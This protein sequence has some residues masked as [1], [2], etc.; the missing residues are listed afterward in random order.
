MKFKIVPRSVQDAEAD[1]VIDLADMGMARK[2]IAKEVYGS[3][4]KGEPSHS[5]LMRIQHILSYWGVGVTAYRNG[6]NKHGKAVIAAIRREGDV[7][8]SIR[9]A[10]KEVAALVRKTG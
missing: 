1:Q 6:K 5:S 2:L 8:G 9:A 7:L 3:D 10:Q 4:S